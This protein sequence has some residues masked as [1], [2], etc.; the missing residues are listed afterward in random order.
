MSTCR[1]SH[2]V[3]MKALHCDLKSL[4]RYTFLL[5]VALVAVDDWQKILYEYT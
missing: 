5:P 3:D 4:A 1:D 2:I